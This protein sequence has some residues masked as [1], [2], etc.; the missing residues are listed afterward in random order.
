MR[1]GIDASNLNRGG[2]LTHLTELLAI[3]DAQAHGFDEIVVWGTPKTLCKLRDAPILRKISPPALRSGSWRRFAWQ[4][5]SLSAAATAAGCDVLFVPGGSFLGS[6]RP[7]VTMSRNM[8]PFSPSEWRYFHART[9]LKLRL[10]RPVQARSFRRADGLIFLTR[11]AETA[12]TRVLPLSTVQRTVIPHGVAESFRMPPRPQRPL[13]NYSWEAPLTLLYVSPI[14]GYKHQLEVLRAMQSD[15]LASLPIRLR[16][17]GLCLTEKDGS[18]FRA[19]LQ[20]V[21]RQRMVV[22][23]DGEV[24][25]RDLPGIFSTSD[26]GIFAS[27]CENMP[28]TLLE[29]MAA[30]LPIAASERPPMPEVLGD[31][32]LYFDPESPESIARTLHEIIVNHEKRTLLASRAYARAAAFSWRTCADRTFQHLANVAVAAKQRSRERLR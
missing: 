8:L 21:N 7:F 22:S 4:R 10:L 12:I 26:V 29:Y 14:R 9:R 5:F 16:L 25:Y 2:G 27:S 32:G 18:L 1:L 13:A 30:G 31:A 24:A 6:F 20:R 17:V 19:E 23:C 3:G 28:N 11:Y 15:L